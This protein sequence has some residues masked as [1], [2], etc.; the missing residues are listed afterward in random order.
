MAK[1]KVY[2]T[3]IL[4]PM[5]DDLLARVD[6]VRG[7]IDR[8]EFIRQ[9]VAKEVIRLEGRDAVLQ[10]HFDVIAEKVRARQS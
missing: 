8:T 7:T 4:L 9:A 10:S 3:R 1:P 6:A 2:N 5:R